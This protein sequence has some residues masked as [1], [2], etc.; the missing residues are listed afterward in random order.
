MKKNFLLVCMICVLA[1]CSISNKNDLDKDVKAFLA[2]FNSKL[3]QSD[4][5]IWKQFMTLQNKDEIFKV[6]RILQNRESKDITAKI[7]FDE[8]S[9]NWEEGLLNIKFPVDFLTTENE[10]E[11]SSLQ[12]SVLRKEG[13]FYVGHIE[14][15]DL[16]RQYSILR[17]KI[18]YAGEL[19][20]RLADVKIFYD[21]AKLLQKDYDSV[22]WY[23]NHN[24]KTYY[25][26]VNGHYDFDSLKKEVRQDFKMGLVDN[27]GKIIVP[28][29]FDLIGNPSISLVDAVEVRKNGKVGCYSM[30][31]KEIIPAIYDWLLP[32][33]NGRV[34]ALVKKDSTYG[35]IDIDYIFFSSFYFDLSNTTAYA[36]IA[37]ASWVPNLLLVEFFKGI[38]A[39]RKA[40]HLSKA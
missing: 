9:S 13:K 3:S 12:L 14:G 29:E 7:G 2:D 16:F 37:W 27:S 30:E 25:Y 23:V 32:H 15:E 4:E 1:A 20:K 5:V 8:I 31:G 39:Q 35:W 11:Q 26:V 28:V 36:I 21:E 40:R 38:F 33:E 19:E 10:G 34:I 18:E 24:Y 17:N 22:I 6:I